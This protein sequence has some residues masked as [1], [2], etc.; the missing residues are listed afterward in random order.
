MHEHWKNG[1]EDTLSTLRHRNS[2]SVATTDA[3]LIVHDI[4]RVDD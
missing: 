3:G 1:H 4:H 2:L